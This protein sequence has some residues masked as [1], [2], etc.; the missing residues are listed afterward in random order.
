MFGPLDNI[1]SSLDPRVGVISHN[2]ELKRLDAV[3]HGAEVSAPVA[4]GS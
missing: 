3:T 2:A 4:R 1:N